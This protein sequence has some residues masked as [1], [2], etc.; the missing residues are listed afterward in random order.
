ME[1]V[2]SRLS[3]SDLQHAVCLHCEMAVIAVERKGSALRAVREAHWNFKVEM[4]NHYKCRTFRENKETISLQLPTLKEFYK[5]IT[6]LTDPLS[7]VVIS[8]AARFVLEIAII[9]LLFYLTFLVL[10]SLFASYFLWIDY[11]VDT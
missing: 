8:T 11:V 7:V 5:V 6:L 9:F 10:F 2:Q 4:I 3:K 1:T